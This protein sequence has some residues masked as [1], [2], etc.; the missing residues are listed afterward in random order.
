[1]AKGSAGR[2]AFRPIRKET[3][4]ESPEDLWNELRPVRKHEFL[5]GPQQEVLK[6]Y[7]KLADRSDVALELPTG[8]GKT[9]VA[10]LIAEWRRRR[11]QKPVTYL[12]LTNQLAGQAIEEASILGIPSADVRGDRFNRDQTAEGQY[13]TAKAVGITTYSNLFNFNP[14]VVESDLLV[15]DDVHGGQEFVANKWT[16]RVPEHM[17]EYQEMLAALAPAL[18][19]RQRRSLEQRTSGQSPHLVHLVDMPQ[20]LTPLAAILDTTSEKSVRFPWLTIKDHIDS[21]VVLV[22]NDS[23]VVRPIVPPT[24][25]HPQ[26]ANS[27]QRLFLSATLGNLADLQR[28]YGVETIDRL[29]SSHQPTGRRF[30]FT[31]S[32]YAAEEDVEDCVAQVWDRVD[33]QRAL[34]ITP[35]SAMADSVLSR[36]SDK[37][38]TPLSILR[39]SDVADSLEPFTGSEGVVLSVPGRYDGIDLPHE[40]CRLMVLG[41]SPSA[42]GEL[43]RHLRDKWRAGPLLRSREV[44]R[45]VQGL[46]RCTRADTDYAVV[47]LVGRAISDMVSRG[48][49]VDSLPPHIRAEVRWGLEQSQEIA[50]SPTAFVEM[51]LGLVDDGAYRAEA[52]AAIVETMRSDTTARKSS[53]DRLADVANDELR[54]AKHVWEGFHS[55]AYE[56]ARA[57]ANALGGDELS[58]YRAWWWYLASVAAE[59]AGNPAN[60]LDCR[61]RA[62]ACGIQQAFIQSLPDIGQLAGAEQETDDGGS[63]LGIWDF[64]EQEIGW[65]GEGL[66]KLGETL[67]EELD[68]SKATQF[69]MG[70]ER[71]GQVLGAECTRSKEAGA[72]DV[73]WSFED[74]VHLAFEAKSGKEHGGKLSKKE[75]LQANGHVN[76]VKQRLAVDTNN[77]VIHPIVVSPTSAT[78]EDARVHVGELSVVSPL[79]LREFSRKTL[80]AIAEMR[81][82]FSGKEY[83]EVVQEWSRL[84]VEHGLDEESIVTMFTSERVATVD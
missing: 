20:C 70:L 37:A 54:Y 4:P 12:A 65:A 77:C 42:I 68:D 2:P 56:A 46:G 53:T 10:L 47:M 36:I 26:Y 38:K 82:T 61:R 59:R 76:W 35:S 29:S 5:R 69:H 9:A 21:C 39:A 45:F 79:A 22:S 58:G 41:G 31:P 23:I 17:E 60:A 78:Y 55:G 67:T 81:A 32:T 80:K 27:T 71:L 1:M 33:P 18:G 57:V 51:A 84:L 66:R 11:S 13:K 50:T 83:A 28:A 43:E 73:V 25:D 8:T 44:T 74:D 75:V 15:L 19:V 14:V 52:D 24:Y 30:V 63:S 64:V 6:E 72:P 16:V 40:D 49:F 7:S 34:A 48:A 62:L 3:V